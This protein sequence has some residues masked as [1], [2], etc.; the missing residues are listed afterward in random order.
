MFQCQQSHEFDLLLHVTMSQREEEDLK[1]RFMHGV[2]G[3]AKT[4]FGSSVLVHVAALL[5]LQIFTVVVGWHIIN[6]AVGTAQEI[7][8]KD[9]TVHS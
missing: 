2:E 4:V 9:R 7:S 6:R 3:S 8:C 5:K 1:I